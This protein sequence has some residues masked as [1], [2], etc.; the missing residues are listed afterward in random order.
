[1]KGYGI[2]GMKQDE[3]NKFK[4][5]LKEFHR[6]TEQFYKK[7]ITVPQ[8]KSVSGGYGSYA[9]R[10]GERSMLR[11]RLTGG[12]IDRE[13][14]EFIKDSIEK[15]QIDLV[16]FTTCQTVQLHNLTK[17]QVCALV[18]EA[19][20][21][22]IITIGGGGDFPRNVMCSPLSGVEEG[23][24]FNVFPY[25]KAAEEYLLTIINKVTL[26]RK[27]K[28][29]FSNGAKNETH[30]TFRDLGFVA[31]ENLTF[32]VYAAGG[33]GIKPKM[34]V[35]VAEHIEPSKI[36]Y[37]IK[38]MVDVFTEYGNYENRAASRSR[39]LQDTLSEEGLKKI[40][41]DKLAQNLKQED[42]DISVK[43]GLIEK[44]GR[45]CAVEEKDFLANPRVIKQKQ[46]G[47]YAVSYH[48][49]GGKPKPS[50]FKKLYEVSSH[51]PEVTIRLTPDQGLYVIHLTK[52]EAEKILELTADDT[53]TLFERST[54][55]IGADICQVG[56]G[57]SQLLLENCLERVKKEH[58]KNGVLPAI[59][60]SGCPS[61]CGTHQTA[62]LGFRG[63]KKP[64]K[65]G[66]EFA[67]AVYENGSEGKGKE[68]FGK[69]LGVMLEKDIPEFLVELG[70]EI[71]KEDVTFK[72]FQARY[73]ERT[74]QV[75]ERYI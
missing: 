67:F 32:Q 58:F 54:A 65:N 11:L 6:V 33:L 22:G 56:I 46:K 63:G 73:P 8:Y 60:I 20:E 39:F 28:V 49:I 10:G 74:A 35:L 5:D 66:P 29:C 48:P 19:F 3:V 71:S 64:T 59:H 72:E 16:H 4:E 2:V 14:L 30:A 40:F 9:Q 43:E 18:G 68:Q 37:C 13:S 25:A 69:E 75:A 12:E 42:M 36:L 55:C 50:F 61:S 23:E 26:P 47:L 17:E 45:D 44:E 62:S 15:Y 1:M 31:D 7:E 53:G 34:G 38:T 57:K 51:M 52:E 21:H 41:Q 70:R 27:L 24:Y